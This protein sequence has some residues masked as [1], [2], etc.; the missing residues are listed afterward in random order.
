MADVGAVDLDAE[1]ARLLEL[2]QGYQAS[3]QVLTI[4]QQL[5]DTILN[6]M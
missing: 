5:F 1:A 3:A 6:S 2:Q 4:A